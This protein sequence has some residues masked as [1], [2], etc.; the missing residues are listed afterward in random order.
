MSLKP[1]YS[2]RSRSEKVADECS[3]IV[4]T[5]PIAQ[6]VCWEAVLY[7]LYI[8][9][10]ISKSKFEAMKQDTKAEQFRDLFP[11]MC[12]VL[13]TQQ[14]LLDLPRGCILGFFKRRPGSNGQWFLAHAMIY[15]GNG[16]AYGTNNSAIGQSPAWGAIRLDDLS[17]FSWDSPMSFSYAEVGNS[18]SRPDVEVRYRD[19]D[20][21]NT[22]GCAIM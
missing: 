1:N 10:V 11:M 12:S 18:G 2:S 14:D 21:F 16:Q 22:L 19:I 8:K 6:Y 7:V 3:R 4:S 5:G 13:K 15:V 20:D 17:V 9:N